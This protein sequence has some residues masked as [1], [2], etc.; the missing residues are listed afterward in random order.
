[1]KVAA[2]IAAAG[3]GLRM[4]AA[5]RKQYFTLGGIPVLARSLKLFTGHRAVTEVIA[6]IPPGEAE[7]VRVLLQP[8]LPSEQIKLV[9]GGA[10][11][12]TSVARGLALIAE[13][14]ELV[15][16]HDAARPLASS[17]LLDRLIA[18]AARWGAAIPV[19]QPSDTIKEVDREDFVVKTLQRDKLR[20]VQTPQVF[21]LDLILEAYREAEKAGLTATDDASLIEMIEKPVKTL[22]GEAGNIKITKP[23]DFLVAA[24]LLEGAGEK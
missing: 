9:E 18:A 2:V 8:H 10:T 15:C 21:R 20:L 12:Q 17:D 11:R 16:I 24:L 1:M 4:E 14:A 19:L 6:V 22:P 5:M 3:A 13:D 7:A 23:D